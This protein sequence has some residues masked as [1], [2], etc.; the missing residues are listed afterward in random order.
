[1]AQRKKRATLRQRKSTARSQGGKTRKPTR[2]KAAKRTVAKS[3]PAKR[4][5][6][7]RPKRPVAKK[8]ARKRARPVKPPSTST[9]E[10]VTVDVIEETAPGEITITEFEETEIREEGEV[11]DRLRK[12]VRNQ[13]S[14]SRALLLWAAVRLVSRA[15][16][17]ADAL[18]RTT[19]VHA[20]SDEPA[21]GVF[22]PR[23]AGGPDR[24]GNLSQR[25]E[26][27][28][29]SAHQ[30]AR[31]PRRCDRGGL[32]RSYQRRTWEAT[33]LDPLT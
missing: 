27:L 30:G 17:P 33:M 25:R 14:D 22:N 2:G 32:R 9:V 8:V 7:A 12:H 18:R 19:E 24:A 6:K 26:W 5:A 21:T 23:S 29:R 20:R 16:V 31:A 10:T 1:M 15:G 28:L 13:K 11:P 4:L 3:K